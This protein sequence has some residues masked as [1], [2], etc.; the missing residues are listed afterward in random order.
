MNAVG[1]VLRVCGGRGGGDSDQLRRFTGFNYLFSPLGLML[2][3]ADICTK[4]S[5]V[6]IWKK[7]KKFISAAAAARKKAKE[8]PVRSA[9]G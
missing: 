1:R 9:S 5:S 6:L 8:P 2:S 7:I 4:Q 3:A